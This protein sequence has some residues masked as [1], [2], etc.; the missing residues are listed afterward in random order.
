MNRIA[1]NEDVSLYGSVVRPGVDYIFDTPNKTYPDGSKGIV[2][3]FINSTLLVGMS[4]EPTFWF[5]GDKLGFLKEVKL[6]HTAQELPWLV[7]GARFKNIPGTKV[8]AGAF[9]CKGL[10]DFELNGEDER[11]VGVR[12]WPTTR[13]FLTGGFGF[14]IISS[15]TGGHGYNIDV[16][17]EGSIVMKGFEGQHGFSQLRLMAN[18]DGRL[19]KRLVIEN[20][21]LHDTCEGEPIYIGSTQSAPIPRFENVSISNGIIARAAAEAIQLQNMA[22]SNMRNITVFAGQTN[23]LNAFQNYQSNGFQ[24]VANG[25]QNKI[26]KVLIDGFGTNGFMPHS[27]APSDYRPQETNEVLL[28]DVLFYNGRGSGAYFNKSCSNG[29]TWRLK[30]VMF[31]GFNNSWY[32]NT[33]NPN[34]PYLFRTGGGTDKIIIERLIHDGSKPTLFDNESKYQID[35]IVQEP[36]EK[37]VYRNSGF[38][39]SSDK[40]MQWSPVYA[41]YFP[42]P[43]NT[44]VQWKKGDIAIDVDAPNGKYGFYKCLIDHL[45]T[46]IRP[47][48]N[49]SFRHLT[50]DEEGTRNDRPGWNEA[51]LQSM[52]PPDD[53]R[54]IPG[55]SLGHLGI[56][57]EPEP[58]KLA[59]KHG[60]IE[61]YFLEGKRY[62][63]TDNG[64][65]YINNELQQLL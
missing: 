30:N 23:W 62:T 55:H 26:S 24:L 18:N 47:S 38:H 52:F 43:D 7:S 42:G 21:Y 12:H 8:C 28:E 36:I 51:T 17:E 27:C 4:G 32:E 33:G 60:I 31:G 57:T 63:L 6:Q 22:G 48:A 58:V 1:G 64:D 40:I 19:V 54:L 35:E 45:A 5:D 10:K 34:V 13:K 50:W 20:F 53:L 65:L 9:T 44:P 49:P 14:H 2:H 3:Y 41:P 11:F 25:G 29:I 37:P 15:L 39:E 56:E 16:Q 46:P 59:K 61:D